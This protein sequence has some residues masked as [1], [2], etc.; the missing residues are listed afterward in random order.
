MPCLAASSLLF[1]FCLA[2]RK[3]ISQR[4]ARLFVRLL[5]FD[6]LS[7][8]ERSSQ[9]GDVVEIPPAL[10]LRHLLKRGNEARAKKLDA[11][12]LDVAM[13]AVQNPVE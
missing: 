8:S 10:G 3:P 1:H 5:V 12:R 4:S 13:L 7:L 2:E 6:L 11:S 9:M